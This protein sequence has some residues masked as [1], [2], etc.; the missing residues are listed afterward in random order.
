MAFFP[1]EI[2]N[3]KNKFKPIVDISSY[4]SA[5]NKYT[6]PEDGY[7]RLYADTNGSSTY[8]NVGV[9]I[10]SSDESAYAMFTAL[11]LPRAGGGAVNLAYVKRGMKAY[12][13]ING[14][15]SATSGVGYYEFKD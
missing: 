13:V 14:T 9:Y 7:V 4:N 10:Y 11:S 3:D 6:F 12:C 15:A 2:N 1:G 8:A 5:S